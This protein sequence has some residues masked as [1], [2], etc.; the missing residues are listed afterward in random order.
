MIDGVYI[1]EHVLLVALG[2]DAEGKKHV[3][4]LREGA[5][6]NA[7]SCT[8]LLGDMRERG[9]HTERGVLAI[10][11]G[12]KALTKAVRDVYGS[13][14]LLRRRRRRAREAAARQPRAS[15]ARRASRRGGFARR[16]PRRDAHRE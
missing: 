14:A 12:S 13:R 3:L 9:S 10:L 5:T 16:G 11:A 2:I 4:G 6:E 15:P 8:A 1:D 7:A